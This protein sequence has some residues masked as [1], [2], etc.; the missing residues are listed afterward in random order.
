MNEPAK[1]NECDGSDLA[2]PTFN[3][4]GYSTNQ[5]L[6][7]RELFAA[8]AMQSLVVDPPSIDR[9]LDAPNVPI[10]TDIAQAAVRQADAL[11]AA[12]N[13]PTA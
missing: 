1:E 6:T 5:G 11:I 13:Q 7:K 12:L 2:F 9:D 8:M 4:E 3:N 10:E